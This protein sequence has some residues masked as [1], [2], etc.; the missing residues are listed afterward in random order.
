MIFV[1]SSHSVLETWNAAIASLAAYT[2]AGSPP[3]LASFQASSAASAAA[4]SEPMAPPTLAAVALTTPPPPSSVRKRSLTR[5]MACVFCLARLAAATLGSVPLI[6]AVASA[7]ALAAAA[8]T[9]S[10]ASAA[11]SSSSAWN[12]L[13][14]AAFD[15]LT[16]ERV[17]DLF[18]SPVETL[19]LSTGA[20]ARV[21]LTLESHDT[22]APEATATCCFIVRFVLLWRV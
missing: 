15:A 22:G 1:R 13:A 8:R 18:V 6:A 5:S 2:C 9:S 4:A 17:D 10:L 12:S 19:T 21:S 3:S 7:C 16:R 14:S 20:A 11:Q